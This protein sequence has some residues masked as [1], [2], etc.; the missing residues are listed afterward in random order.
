MSSG[1]I[2]KYLNSLKQEGKYDNE[3]IDILAGCNEDDEDGEIVAE[4]ILQVINKRYAE[5]KKNKT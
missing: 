1:I 2:K 4:K 5:D 3:F